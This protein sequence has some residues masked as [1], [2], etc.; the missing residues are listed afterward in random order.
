MLVMKKVVTNAR[1][2]GA[3]IFLKGALPWKFAMVILLWGM[4]A[5]RNADV[6]LKLQKK[7]EKNITLRNSF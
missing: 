5:M 4:H 6:A 2:V 3:K 7:T 1:R